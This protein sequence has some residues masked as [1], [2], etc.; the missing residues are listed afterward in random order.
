[1]SVPVHLVLVV[2]PMR[3]EVE[4]V[5]ACLD[6]I[7]RAVDS[8]SAR[9]G[10]GPLRS[11]TPR[12]RVVAALDLCTDGT[13]DAVAE[14]SWVEPVISVA[15]RVGAARALGVRHALATET[16]AAQH[17]WIATTDAD[18]RVPADWLTYQVMLARA[19]THLFRGLVEPDRAECGP[20]AY[21]AWLS[22]YT[23]FEGHGHVHGANLGVRADAY[24]AC[25]GFDELAAV[26]EDVTL[27]TAAQLQAMSVVASTRARVATSGRLVGRVNG[28]GFAAYLSSA[29]NGAERA[30]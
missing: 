7:R 2:V 13:D 25:G 20:A 26:D 14:Y 24:Y 17:I 6:S 12:I 27:S 19:G 21:D 1:M 16:V 28:T 15:G 11:P 18:S 9:N 4:R 22:G 23:Q 5:R 3:D 29:R 8:L 30:S 10:D